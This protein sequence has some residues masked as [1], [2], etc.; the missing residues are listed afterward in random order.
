MAPAERAG[1]LRCHAPL[2][3]QAGDPVLRGD[4]VSCAGCHVRGWVRRGPP[5]VSPQLLPL[6]GYPAVAVGLYERADFC[7]PCHQLPPR[8]AVA[9]R[10]LLDTYREWLDGPYMPRGVQCQ[11]C[12]LPS[13]EHAMLGVHD[14]NTFR[15][16]IALDASAHRRGAAVTAV[17][18]VKNIG[19]GHY[20]PTT[21][22]PAAWLS[23]ALIDAHGRAIAGATDRHRIGRDVWFDGEWHERGDTRIPPGGSVTF[24]RAWTAGRT[25]EAAAARIAI[26]VHP[27]DY[28]ER[29]YAAQL[30]GPLAPAQRALY[31][32]ALARALGSH[33]IAEQRD[34]PIAP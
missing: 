17:A 3:E 23:I 4:G 22:T 5:G 14:P 18:T 28:Y 8:V 9:G 1:C 10:P 12:H 2:A 25:A 33:Y 26:E 29:F 16:G 11:H 7:L 13:R 32:Q 30:A 21:P 20:L 19:A 24:A 15:Q 31:Q 34:V 6:P 27:D